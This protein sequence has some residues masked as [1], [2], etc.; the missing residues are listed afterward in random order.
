MAGLQSI[1]DER[2]VIAALAL[3]QRGI[4]RKAIAKAKGAEDVPAEAVVEFKERVT[5]VL[6]HHASAILLDPEYGLPATKHR[7]AAGLLLAY[8]QSCYDAAPP[9]MPVLYDNWSVRRV[10]EAGADCVKILLH[11]TPFERP[12]INDI[13]S[14]WTERIGDE[15]RAQDIPFVLELLGYDLDGNEKSLAYAKIK[16][17]VVTRSIEEFSKDRY[18]VD[19]LKIEVPVQLGFVAGTRFFRGEQAYARS[20]AQSHFLRVASATCKPFVYL[21]AGVSN[22]EFIETLEFAAECG[23]RFNGVLCGRATWQDG[24]AIYAQHGAKALEDWLGTAGRENIAR[25]NQAVQ[26]AQSWPELLDHSPASA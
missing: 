14:A 4:L 3:D 5:S 23:S 18:G 1:S 10:K 11:Y 21:S 2:G 19:L 20:E 26:A 25:V 22:A 9:R 7:N 24:I 17:E 12:E 15:C 8:E 13:K 16:P 6:T